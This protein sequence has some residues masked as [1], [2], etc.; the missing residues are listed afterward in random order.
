MRTHDK[1]STRGY[2][3]RNESA[4]QYT[5][6]WGSYGLAENSEEIAVSIVSELDLPLVIKP[7]S[8]SASRGIS[9]ARD[10]DELLQAVGKAREYGTEILAEQYLT[11]TEHSAE[12]LLHNG[13]IIW[14]NIVDR[15]F[16]YDKGIPLELGHV[17]SS[18]LTASQLS[19]IHI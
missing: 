17:N 19:L 5:V 6:E 7:I 15:V 2:L 12:M 18:R 16:S 3:E 9:I 10:D 4:S 13:S 8:Q 1:S 11:G 14:F